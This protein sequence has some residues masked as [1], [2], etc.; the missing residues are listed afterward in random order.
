MKD[1]IIIGAGGCGREVL[2]WARDINEKEPC[3]N[4]K[5]FL[6]DDRQALEGLKCSIPILGS[7]DDYSIKPED[8]FVCCIG[9]SNVRKKIID[10]MKAK[11]ASFVTLIHPNA[12]IADTAYI[13]SGV[14]IYPFALISDNAVIG[15]GCI[16]NMYS[17]VAHDSKLGEYCTISAH[18]DI[19]GM[20]KLGDRVFMG[21]TS[22][23]VPGTIIGNDVYICA[24]STV[25]TKT[26]DGRKLLGNPAKMIQF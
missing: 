21:T 6:D 13:G 10:K 2:Q 24:G 11:G 25:M 19:T 17:S 4:I 15:D 18:C 3:W 23:I 5:G 7:V 14:I 12:V 26:R 16:I 8:I 22:N 9:N 1:L 20:C